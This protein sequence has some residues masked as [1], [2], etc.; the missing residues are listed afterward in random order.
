MLLVHA[1]LL[2]RPSPAVPADAKIV[3]LLTACY[4]ALPIARS[5]STR[6]ATW[7]PPRRPSWAQ[8]SATLAAAA[9]PSARTTT[10]ARTALTIRP[11]G[12]TTPARSRHAQSLTKALHLL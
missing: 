1:D 12:Q 6:H 8:A 2:C 9:A 11:V 4:A 10:T 5:A 7:G 3:G